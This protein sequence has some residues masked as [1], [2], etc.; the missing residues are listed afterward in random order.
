MDK[1]ILS[2]SEISRVEDAVA[3]G[4]PAFEFVVQALLDRWA[5]PLRDTETTARLLY[6][7]YHALTEPAVPQRQLAIPVPQL[8]HVLQ[9][10]GGEEKLPPD[11]LFAFGVLMQWQAWPFG[12]EAAWKEIGRR[13]TQLSAALEPDSRLFREWEFFLGDVPTTT[14]PKIYIRPEVNGRYSGRGMFG[15]RM[16]EYFIGLLA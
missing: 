13:W 1:K 5:V 9:Q 12:D 2:L 15:A 11:T 7:L 6:V 3:L 14:G 16:A 4:A 8:A 10:A